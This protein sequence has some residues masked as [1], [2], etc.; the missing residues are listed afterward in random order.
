MPDDS[1][2]GDAG[3]PPA[4]GGTHG[5][6]TSPPGADGSKHPFEK[7]LASQSEEIRTQADDYVKGL[8]TA[9]DRV[10]TERAEAKAEIEKIRKDRS[11]DADGKVKAIQASLEERERKVS[12]YESL[13]P[14]VNNLELAY[15]AVTTASD[16]LDEDG[17]VDLKAMKTRFPQLFSKGPKGFAGENSDNPPTRANSVNRW[18]REQ[19]R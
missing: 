2:P 11:L 10:K 16:L 8:K 1:K 7:F 13:A 3:T 5:E 9:L 14:H 18:I 17:K 4:D 19:A 15:A 6:S 12:V